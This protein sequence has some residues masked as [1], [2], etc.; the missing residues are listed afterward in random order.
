VKILYCHCAHAQVLPRE[1]RDAV[2]E[3]LAGSG[4]AF[5][6]VGDLCEMS[7]RNDPELARLAAG[8]PLR[9]AACYPRAVKWLFHAAK[10]PLAEDAR[11]AN[12]RTDDA[13]TVLAAVLGEQK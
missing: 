2:L 10:A 9:I 8:G 11:V 7:A 13:A 12:M 4:A 1:V 6:A 5:E 3:G